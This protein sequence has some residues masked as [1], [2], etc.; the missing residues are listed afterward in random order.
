[1]ETLAMHLSDRN[2]WR[3]NWLCRVRFACVWLVHHAGRFVVQISKWIEC[4]RHVL[5]HV[6]ALWQWQ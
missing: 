5:R 6:V 1:M 3:R 4:D 2:I